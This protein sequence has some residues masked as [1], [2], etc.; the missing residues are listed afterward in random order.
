VKSIG[1][2]SSA[3]QGINSIKKIYFTLRHSDCCS[4]YARERNL[5]PPVLWTGFGARNTEKKGGSSIRPRVSL[6]DGLQDDR[7]PDYLRVSPRFAS[8]CTDFV[9]ADLSIVDLVDRPHAAGGFVICLA[10]TR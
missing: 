10:N 4:E 5:Q 2:R 8:S 7:W 6:V 9:V 3:S 1:K